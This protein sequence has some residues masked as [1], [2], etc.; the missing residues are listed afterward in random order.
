M[1]EIFGWTAKAD[2]A[3]CRFNRTLINQRGVAMGQ[4][5][6]GKGGGSS[7]FFILWHVLTPLSGVNIQLGPFM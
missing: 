4:E 6:R 7:L 2:V 3:R 5:F 1:V